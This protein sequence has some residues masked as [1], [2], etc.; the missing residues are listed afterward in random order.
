[1][2]W[3]WF[4]WWVVFFDYVDGCLF[5]RNDESRKKWNCLFVVSCLRSELGL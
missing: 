1:M 5:G 2:K 4:M 3:Y